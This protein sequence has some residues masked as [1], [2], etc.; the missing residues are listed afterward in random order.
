MLPLQDRWQTMAQSGDETCLQVVSK[1]PHLSLGLTPAFIL[2]TM[3][4]PP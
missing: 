1:C 3:Y 4:K 2:S